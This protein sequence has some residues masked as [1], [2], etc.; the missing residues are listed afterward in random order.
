MGEIKP[1][2]CIRHESKQ[3]DDVRSPHLPFIAAAGA[4]ATAGKH[5]FSL[6]NQCRR[7]EGE[8]Y[9]NRQCNDQDD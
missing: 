8:T 3:E 1:D 6:P 2:G 9:K 5:V 7:L 4:P